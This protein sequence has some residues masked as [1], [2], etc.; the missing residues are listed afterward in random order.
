MGRCA[1]VGRRRWFTSG[2]AASLHGLPRRLDVGAVGCWFGVVVLRP[3]NALVELARSCVP[4]FADAD[5]VP[6]RV[7]VE[8]QASRAF[9]DFEFDCP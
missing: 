8:L 3:E 6:V 2:R 5:A 4:A 7:D 9:D 1:A